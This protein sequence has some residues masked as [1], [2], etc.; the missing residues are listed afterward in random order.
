MEDIINA[1]VLG[2]DD[3]SD[4]DDVDDVLVLDILKNDILG[5]RAEIYGRF[6]LDEISNVEAKSNF[7][8]EKDDIPRLSNALGIPE[9]IMTQENI[10]LSGK[11]Y[12]F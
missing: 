1:V 5:N 12:T 6:S 8:F 10:Q 9:F 7:R 4:D 3:D 2:E 11:Y